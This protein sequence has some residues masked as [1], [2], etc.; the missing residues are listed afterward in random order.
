M[1]R[2][3][4]G[5]FRSTPQGIA[6]GESGFMPAGALLDHHQARFTLRLCARPRDGDGPEKTL[7]RK[8]SAFTTR[9]RIAAALG[10]RELVETQEWGTG[11]QLPGRIIAD[12]RA[13]ALQTAYERRQQ[14]TTG[15]LFLPGG[16]RYESEE[17]DLKGNNRN[18]G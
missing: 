16:E 4:L 17:T 8:R 13:G 6:A 18:E 5:T 14:D 12:S 15:A 2:S 10:R 9:L 11:R 1:G 3:T 7:T